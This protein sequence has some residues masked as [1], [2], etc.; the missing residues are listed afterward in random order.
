M[1]NET[2]KSRLPNPI[3]GAIFFAVIIIVLFQTDG[4]LKLWQGI[5]LVL[6]LTV[7]HVILTMFFNR[8]KK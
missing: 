4:Q 7:V 3:T 2:K 6:G 1:K 5:L 8:N